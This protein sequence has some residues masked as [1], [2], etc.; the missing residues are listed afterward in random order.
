MVR[1]RLVRLLLP[2]RPGIDWS[3]PVGPWRA[4]YAH[5]QAFGW[6]LWVLAEIR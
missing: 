6:R 4:W 5:V 3:G 1:V 2:S